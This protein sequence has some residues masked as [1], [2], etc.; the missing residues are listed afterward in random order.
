MSG[1]R[2]LISAVVGAIL[3]LLYNPV[4]GATFT[5]YASA[6]SDC[7]SA[8]SDDTCV[9]Y[10]DVEK[11]L[12]KLDF[13]CE[14][15]GQCVIYCEA[16]EC[17]KSSTIY[18]TNANQGGFNLNI[19]NGY[20]KCAAE[21]NVYLPT[22]GDANIYVNGKDGMKDGNFYAG[23]NTKN[24]L[25]DCNNDDESKNGCSKI[26]VLYVCIFRKVPLNYTPK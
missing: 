20:D 14:N 22:S 4:I 21:A 18:A 10:C 1:K 6:G 11:G 13:D 23:S 19:I 5:A 26:N 25:I 17:F 15:A 9:F 2:V 12:T 24:I 3:A 7:S 8:T 16:K